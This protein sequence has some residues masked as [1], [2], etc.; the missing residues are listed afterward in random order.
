MHAPWQFSFGLTQQVADSTLKSNPNYRQRTI[1]LAASLSLLLITLGCNHAG[2]QKDRPDV[3]SNGVTDI[4]ISGSVA[5]TGVTRLGVNISGQNFYDSGQIARNLIFRNPGFE[6][7]MWQSILRCKAVTATSCTDGNQWA[8][9]PANFLESAQFEFISGSAV[10]VTGTVISSIPAD[11]RVNDQGVRINFAQPSKMPSPGD[12]VVVRKTFPGNAQAG[13]W[14]NDPGGVM[15][16]TEFSDLPPGTTG[17]QALKV[18]APNSGQSA[19]VSS[20]FDYSSGHAFV[21]LSG[22]YRLHFWAKGIGGNNK[23][24]VTLIRQSRPGTLFIGK[25]VGLSNKWREY[26][27]DFSAAESGNITSNI[28][29]KLNISGASVLVDDM[30]LSPVAAS[31]TNPTAFRDEVVSALKTLHPGVLRWNDGANTGNSI[32]NAIAGPFARMRAGATTQS[33]IADEISI[34]LHE[35]LQLCQVVGAEPYYVMP[36]GISMTEAKNLIEYLAGSPSTPYGAK[37]AARGQT[38]PWTAVFPTIHLELGNE[39][40]NAIF[41]GS[42]IPDAVVYGSRAKAIFT[43]MRQSPAYIPDKFDLIIGAFFVQP[44]R[45][46]EQLANSGGYDS[47]SVAPYLFNNLSDVSSNEAIFGPMFAQPE[48]YDSRPSGLMTQQAKMTK[49]LAHPAK[50]VVYEVNLSTTSGSAPQSS[51]DAVVPSLGAGLTVVEHMMLMMRDLGVK[52]QAVWSLSGYV[53]SFKNSSNGKDQTTPLFGVVV[54]MGGETNLRRP[55]FL[56]EELANQA[57]LP[58]MLTTTLT[59][60]NPTW[61]QKHSDNDNVQI[62]KAHY[63][64]TFAFSEGTSRSVIVF[65]LSRSQAL[66]ITFSGV[67]APSGTVQLSQLTSKNITDSNEVTSHVAITGTT[68]N[69]FN[70]Q[71]PYSLPPFSMTVFKWNSG[72]LGASF[73]IGRRPSESDRL[74]IITTRD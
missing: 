10:G 11:G 17:K 4:A 66:L 24:Q 40:W 18:T 15:I 26:N 57:I 23:I 7:Q 36:P 38:E 45:T 47:T 19:E 27:L 9:W 35:F 20:Y 49:A 67:G 8:Q 71:T 60:A 68:L 50:L 48:M 56:A 5:Q 53:N 52:T 72:H 28:A 21:R 29:L 43:T 51:F 37:R 6:G 55:Q 34:G 46:K 54:D 25:E 59:G 14:T 65:N 31:S 1:Y 70:P 58:T 44:D 41:H 39:E 30:S 13:W 3:A 33:A 22:P 61:N 16:S 74:Y 32:D 64:Q 62:E 73:P 63:L 2:A 69:G 12:F 42:A